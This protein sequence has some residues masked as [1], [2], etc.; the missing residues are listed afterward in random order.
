ML[1]VVCFI[2]CH[3]VDVLNHSDAFINQ[4]YVSAVHKMVIESRF[5]Q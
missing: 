3:K 4:K 5:S 1:F 2:V